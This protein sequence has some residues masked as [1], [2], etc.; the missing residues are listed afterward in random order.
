MCGAVA[1]GLELV[2]L[3]AHGGLIQLGAD[4]AA[5]GDEL[6]RAGPAQ[7]CRPIDRKLDRSA[8]RQRH[9]GRKQNAT[10]PEVQRAA[11]PIYVAVPRMKDP[12]PYFFLKGKAIRSPALGRASDPRTYFL[13]A[14]IHVYLDNGGM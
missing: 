4:H 13:S 12:I 11:D 6:K 14:G 3:D 2:A 10:T 8:D 5:Y 9:L 1:A 7:S